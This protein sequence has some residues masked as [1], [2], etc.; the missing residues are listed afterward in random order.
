MCLK[1]LGDKGKAG[2]IAVANAYAGNGQSA[3]SGADNLIFTLNM[4]QNWAAT[5]IAKM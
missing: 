5:Q 1:P 2:V 3:Q 4:A